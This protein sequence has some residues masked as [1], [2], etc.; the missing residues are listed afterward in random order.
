MQISLHFHHKYSNCTV[1]DV[2]IITIT[3]FR[4]PP[5][6]KVVNKYY[7]TQLSCYLR[8]SEMGGATVVM[9]DSLNHY[10]PFLGFFFHFPQPFFPIYSSTSRPP[11]MFDA[12]F[13]AIFDP[14]CHLRIYNER[15]KCVISW[16][17]C[18]FLSINAQRSPP[19][20]VKNTGI[21]CLQLRQLNSGLSMMGIV[22]RDI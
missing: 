17:T 9:R 4:R 21:F 7:E 2:N 1:H 12:M 18:I 5:H 19:K 15:S 8:Y 16:F 13:D 22:T 11:A 14:K 6:V 10:N 20:M 3:Q